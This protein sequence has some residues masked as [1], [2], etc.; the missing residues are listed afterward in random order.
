M[1]IFNAHARLKIIIVAPASPRAHCAEHAAALQHEGDCLPQAGVVG[2]LHILGCYND[3]GQ[4]LVTR[5]SNEGLRRFHN[6]GEGPSRAPKPKH[7][8]LVS[9]HN[10]GTLAQSS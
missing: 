2:H 10:I 1:T 5:A 8:K 6:R 4:W 7:S 9:K 3:D